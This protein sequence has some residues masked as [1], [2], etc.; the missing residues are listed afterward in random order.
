MVQSTTSCFR[1][2]VF[3]YNFIA[4]FLSV[5]IL[6]FN[7]ITIREIIKLQIAY[8]YENTNP[9]RE[10]SGHFLCQDKMLSTLCKLGQYVL[11][12][13]KYS[14]WQLTAKCYNEECHISLLNIYL[15]MEIAAL[16]V[17][18]KHF[19]ESSNRNIQHHINKKTK[20]SFAS[21]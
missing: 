14:Y 6:S 20:I 4:M 18:K 13:T 5:T 11:Y 21:E 19:I 9:T 7:V 12:F 16:L 10:V 2:K 3:I 8:D 17:S 1:C 15:L